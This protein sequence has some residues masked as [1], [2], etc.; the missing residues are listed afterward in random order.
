MEEVKLLKH[1]LETSKLTNQ[2][3]A[4]VSMIPF[5]TKNEECFLVLEERKCL[6]PPLAALEEYSKLSVGIVYEMAR[7]IY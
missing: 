4:N 7:E 1:P 2:A 3:D 5:L 6:L